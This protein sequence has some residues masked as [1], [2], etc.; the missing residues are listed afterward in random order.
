MVNLGNLH[1]LILKKKRLISKFRSSY[2]KCSVRK[3]G[4]R[5]FAK[6]KGKQAL[7]LQL[8]YVFIYYE[9]CEISKNTF[10]TITSVSPSLRF[11]QNSTSEIQKLPTFTE[12]TKLTIAVATLEVTRPQ[13][14]LST[15]QRETCDSWELGW[16]IMSTIL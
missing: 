1:K 12:N 7:G 10:F 13:K 9:F 16:Q 11:Y 6:F 14:L 3:G 5:N 8:Y 4:L 2:W 15:N